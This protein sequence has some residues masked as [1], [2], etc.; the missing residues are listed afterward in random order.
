MRNIFRLLAIF[1]ALFATACSSIPDERVG[2]IYYTKFSFHHEKGKHSATNYQRGTL[3]PI[4]NQ[5]IIKKVS[6]KVIAFTVSASNESLSVVNNPK[7]THSDI[8]Q[9]FDETFSEKRTD[10]SRFSAKEKQNIID[11]KIEKGMSK[12][13]V[14]A[15]MGNPPGNMEP[16][17]SNEWTFWKSKFDTMLVTFENGK[18]SKIKD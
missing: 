12:A 13:A 7:H 4:N 1:T 18:I 16:M 9:I 5:V 8:D 3:L 11:G 10:L 15:A 17:N 6:K 14:L 2:K